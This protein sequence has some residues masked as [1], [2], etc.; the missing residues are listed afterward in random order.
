M[1]R[2]L[3]NLT[4]RNCKSIREQTLA[5]GRLNVFIG[6][7]GTGKSNLIEAFRFLREIVKQGRRKSPEMSFF[8]EFGEGDR[9]NADSVRLRSTDDDILTIGEEMAFYHDRKWHPKPYSK[10]VSSFSKESRLKHLEHICTRQ[11]MHDLDSYRAY[12]FHDTSET[13][14]VKGTCDL[15]DNR[16]LRHPFMD[17]LQQRASGLIA[18]GKNARTSTSG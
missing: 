4:I 6:G 18:F 2:T 16:V 14:G 5:L 7:N 13:A 15:E 12:H 8:L 9:S 3:E 1:M 11:V 17:R 10:P